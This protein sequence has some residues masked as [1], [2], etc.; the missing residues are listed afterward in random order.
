MFVETSDEEKSEAAF[1]AISQNV[2]SAL[3]AES[4]I[5]KD[6]LL[7][8]FVLTKLDPGR[9][10]VVISDFFS[11]EKVIS[12]AEDWRKAARNHPPFWVFLPPSIKGEK[13]LKT[14]PFCIS[15]ADFMRSFHFQWLRNGKE[16]SAVPGVS[17]RE[18]Y[19]LFLSCG[20]SEGK[21]I[22]E[23]FLRLLL[24]RLTPLFFGIGQAKGSGNWV[25]ISE[26]SKRSV[27]KGFSALAIL[28]DKLGSKK[29]EFMKGSAFYLG[30]LFSLADTLHKEYC[31]NVRKNQK[32]P[33]PPQLIGNALLGTAVAN[34]EKG[35]ARLRERIMIYKAWAD[36]A[37][38]EE[39]KLAKWA[40]SQMGKV[41]NE[42]CNLELPKTSDDS[43]KAQI[44][45]GYLS[46]S[47]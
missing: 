32:N 44:F 22:A 6:S 8:L 14:E 46:Y 11:V 45:L 31:V 33:I 13:A 40:L 2:C 41:S 38:G 39:F 9:K 27:L 20:S 5:K 28:L 34:P 19:N 7:R 23:K 10:Q 12:G 43:V 37:S 1:E 47:E 4:G 25:D 3:N 16:K 35:L 21:K 17:L 36:K 24:N 42:L 18:V 15:P 29:E 30:R 26:D